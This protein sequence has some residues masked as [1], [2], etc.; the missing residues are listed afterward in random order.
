MLMISIVHNDAL[1]VAT[2][3]RP[4]LLR[5]A[6]ELRRETIELGVTARQAT[7][8]ALVEARPEITTSELAAAEGVSVP[9]MSRHVERLDS[10]GLVERVRSSADRRRVALVLTTRGAATL[11]AV[12]ERRTAW[13]AARLEHLD[14]ANRALV[15]AA[16]PA[17]VQLVEA[18]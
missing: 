5:L 18:S 3:L 6:R 9:S 8:L 1:L 7:L 13:L 16:V 4:V 17:L 10:L 11:R 15:A 2:E 12:R 14:D